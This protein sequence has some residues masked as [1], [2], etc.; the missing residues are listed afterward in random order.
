MLNLEERE[1]FNLLRNYDSDPNIW[2]RNNSLER[3]KERGPGRLI[4]Q[5]TEKMDEGGENREKRHK[6]SLTD[7]KSNKQQV[8]CKFPVSNIVYMFHL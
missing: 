7:V 5:Q 4:I 8:L 3:E 1:R 2:M 6:E